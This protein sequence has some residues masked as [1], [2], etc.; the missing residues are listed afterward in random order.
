M[1]KQEII[2][3]Y[4]YD[5][6]EYVSCSPYKVLRHTNKGVWLEMGYGIKP[7]F[8]L[9]NARKR[10]AYPTKKEALESFRMRKLRQI[11]YC[12]NMVTRCH[13]ALDKIAPEM[14]E[15]QKQGVTAFFDPDKEIFF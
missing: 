11:E 10:F 14:T 6:Y 1:A 4:R 15:R 12:Q 2:Y 9:N 8:V 3:W 5:G 13:K 7:K